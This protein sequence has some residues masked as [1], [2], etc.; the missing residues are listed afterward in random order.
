MQE[1]G[2]GTDPAPCSFCCGS[3]GTQLGCHAQPG[4]PYTMLTALTRSLGGR[5]KRLIQTDRSD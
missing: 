3:T 1:Q 4:T 5:G 2:A